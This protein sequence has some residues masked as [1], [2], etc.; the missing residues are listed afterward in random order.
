MYGKK[1]SRDTNERTSLFRNLVT[2]LLT[3][4]T[5]ETSESKA[6]AIKGL[7]DKIINLAKSKNT[8]RLLQSYITN[9]SLQ[10][11]LIKEITPKLGSRVS[12]YTSLI[13][14]GK[15]LGDNA[16]MVRMSLIGAEDLSPVIA[17]AAEVKTE[18]VS[19]KQKVTKT[20]TQVVT[21]TKSAKK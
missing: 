13:R 5:I 19:V 9:K 14:V 12:G 8:Q 6:K 3:H 4:G 7:V 1:F 2:A 18:K 15:R 16:T 20:K 17:A 21:K 10:E 11:R